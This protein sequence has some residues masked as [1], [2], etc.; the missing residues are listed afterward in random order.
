MI[1]AG[2]IAATSALGQSSFAPVVKQVQPRMVKI[3]GAGGPR[4]LEAY[5]SGFLISSDGHILTVWS[6][7]LDADLI[8]AVLDDGRRFTA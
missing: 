7:V 1:L 3:Y 6:Y 4:G 5:Q 2:Q 8:T